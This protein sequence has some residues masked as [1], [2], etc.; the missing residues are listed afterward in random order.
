MIDALLKP[1]E[2]FANNLFRVVAFGNKVAAN[3]AAG[4]VYAPLTVQPNSGADLH[5]FILCFSAV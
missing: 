5:F 2:Q 1:Q 4:S 3:D